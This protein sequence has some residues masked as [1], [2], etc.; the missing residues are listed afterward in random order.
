MRRTAPVALA[1]AA[2]G[3]LV[4]MGA[5]AVFDGAFALIELVWI[6]GA[7][8]IGWPWLPLLT[9]TVAGAA[10]SLLASKYGPAPGPQAPF[11]GKAARAGA[12]SSETA[13]DET[14]AEKAQA[15]AQPSPL[16]LRLARFLLP[17][18]GGGPVGVAMGIVG[19]LA[20]GCS[21]VCRQ[22]R[23]AARRLGVALEADGFS[24]H[25]KALL[26]PCAIV[27]GFAGSGLV[28]RFFGVGMTLPRLEGAG[29]G[30]QADPWSILAVVAVS[31]AAGWAMGLLYLASAHA[32]R[33][34]SKR[35]GTHR[36]WA[37]LLCGLALGVLTAFFPHMGLPGSDAYSFHILG[38]WP[39]TSPAMLA[40]TGVTRVVVIGFILNLGWTGGPFLPL[41]FSALCVGLS[42]AGA[43]GLPPAICSAPAIAA[44]L[45]AFSGKPV[46]GVAALLACPLECAVPIAAASLVAWVL[47]MPKAL[48]REARLA[49]RP[50]LK[51]ARER[52]TSA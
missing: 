51:T 52:G 5:M 47:P 11:A 36:A 21:W 35:L 20:S 45:V 40:F 6:E 14:A 50:K 15:P 34:V 13:D 43:T 25:Q 32:A 44:I 46:M 48:A 49:E 7:R 19:F 24:K 23:E 26:Y 29:L 37:P 41:L 4:G 10:L 8:A 12:P 38:E 9:C 28:I 22:G 1:M 27:C 30:L 18:V 33:R 2:L 17:I 39:D 3:C 31:T 42:L 16:P